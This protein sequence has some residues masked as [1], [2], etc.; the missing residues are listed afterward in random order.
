[1]F[2]SFLLLLV[3]FEQHRLNQ[4]REG[5]SGVLHMTNGARHDAQ[6]GVTAAALLKSTVATPENRSLA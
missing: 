3:V 5:S 6:I 4:S 1:L 2:S